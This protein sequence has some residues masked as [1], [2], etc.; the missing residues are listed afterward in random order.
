MELEN[1]KKNMI[2]EKARLATNE[3]GI[4]TESILTVHVVGAKNLL[5][6]DFGHSSDPYV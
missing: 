3:Y 5:P 2:K 4:S 6:R 1:V